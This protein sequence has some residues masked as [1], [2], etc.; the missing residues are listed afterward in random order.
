[1]FREEWPAAVCTPRQ[2]A[3]DR[4]EPTQS[5]L[6]LPRSV[7]A[8][9][10]SSDPDGCWNNLVRF[11][12]AG[13]TKMIQTN[14]TT[15]GID[16]SKAKLDIAVHGRTERWQVANALPGWRALAANLAEAGVTRVGIEATGGYERGVVEH[17][18]AAG[19]TVL[20]LQPLQVKAFGRI[21]LRRAKNDALDAVLIAACAAAVDP[22]EI[23]P[24]PRLTEL[25]DYLTFL[26]QIEEDIRRF[27]TRLEHIDEPTLRRI[28]NSDIARLK[29]RKTAQMRDIAKRL[30]SHDDLAKRLKLVLSIPGI[31]E[32][33]AL[34]IVIRMRELGRVSREEAAALAG[35]APFDADSG[36]HRGQRKIAGGRSRLRRSLF[37]AALPAA[38]RWNKALIALYARL[39]AKGK[40]HN[41]ALIA[42][43][44][45]LLIYANTVVQR[46]TPWTE[47]AAML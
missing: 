45:K 47:K 6:W 3:G 9:A 1:M 36:Q 33:T 21:H 8:S 2:A 17:L 15:A 43:A 42:C 13:L 14:I 30:R 12:K 31:G 34:A 25:A 19:F 10:P 26:E 11:H 24:D 28:V 32:R 37:A 27:K 46:G 5:S 44:R 23:A 29:A 7:I 16:T 18:R 4:I 22:P 20:M 38:F 35:L 41:A 39:M 40:V